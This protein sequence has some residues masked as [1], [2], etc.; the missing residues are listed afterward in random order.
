MGRK[1]KNDAPTK[2]VTVSIEV[3]PNPDANQIDAKQR[4]S[5]L[6]EYHS[7]K[8][9]L[10]ELEQKRMFYQS[11]GGQ[12]LKDH[13]VNDFQTELRQVRADCCVC[14][15]NELLHLQGQIKALERCIDTVQGLRWD[16]QISALKNK[17]EKF[18]N[19]NP[20]FLFNPDDVMPDEPAPAQPKQESP[21]PVD[22]E[23]VKPA[24]PE[25]VEAEEPQDE[26]EQVDETNE[27]PDEDEEPQKHED[28][29]TSNHIAAIADLAD[30][31]I[32]AH[33][34]DPT[35]HESL[36]EGIAAMDMPTQFRIETAKGHPNGQFYK[37][38][39]N[40]GEVAVE[41]RDE[42]KPAKILRVISGQELEAHLA[43]IFGIH[44]SH[45]EAV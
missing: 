42:D 45:R 16:G 34:F 4:D 3:E 25:P 8:G 18:E 33:E 9:R 19:D 6:E 35:A 1:K 7:M 36:L 21:Q 41:L 44:N 11:K 14:K 23:E 27:T 13:I 32:E 26:P 40:T 38:R 29:R 22:I 20:I 30:L 10:E 15:P 43:A 24:D 31:L 28:S 39:P 2:D 37:Q 5:V 17:I 12:A